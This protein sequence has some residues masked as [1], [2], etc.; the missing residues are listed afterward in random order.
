MKK[1]FR[2]INVPSF[3][4]NNFLLISPLLF[5][6]LVSAA[7]WWVTNSQN[8]T[9]SN[10]QTLGN[11]CVLEDKSKFRCYKDELNKIVNEQNPEAAFAFVKEKYNTESYV[12]SQCHQLAHV[13]GRAAY[14]KY[15]EIADTFAHGDQFC[16]SGY[17]H[18]AVEELTDEKGY[19]Y[20]LKNAN[21]ICSSFAASEK[22]SFKHYNCVHGLGHGFMFVTEDRFFDALRACD[23]ITDNWERS[24]CW[25]GVFMQN[26]MNVQG[27]DAADTQGYDY[28]KKDEPMYPCTAVE[29]KYKEQCY[30]MQTSY[31]LQV[32]DYDFKKVFGLCAQSPSAYRSTCYQSLGRDASGQSVSDAART[33]AT[34]L[35]GD[36][37][38]AQSN[39]IIGA[40]KDF[41]SYFHSDVQ[42]KQL[43]AS[44]PPDLGNICSDT[45]K[46]YYSTF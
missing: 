23:N 17:Y 44:L 18:G 43:C 24:S 3:V 39:C 42:A 33:T 11:K 7:F 29:E 36:S 2:K 26:I 38:V 12:K 14:A 46:N 28:L 40:A 8:D 22:Y 1:Q 5:A 10:G 25:G 13:I 9:A 35:L 34:C 6:L 37:S 27:P 4:K 30:L 15:D 21:S 45:V 16:W 41:V 31:A 20:T 19:D 32:V